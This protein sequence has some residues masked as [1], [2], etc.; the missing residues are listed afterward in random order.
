MKKFL[1]A[2]S[3]LLLCSCVHRE[4]YYVFSFDDYSITPGYDD[5]SF[6]DIAFDLDVPDSLEGNEKLKSVNMT[7]FGKYFGDVDLYNPTNKAIDIKDGKLS[8]LVLYFSQ[9]TDHT[10]KIDG[11]DL[12]KSIKKNC[13]IFNGEYIVRNGYACAIGKKVNGKDN[14]IILY[15]DIYAMDQDELNHLEIY[16]EE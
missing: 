3:L 11:V 13:E 1:L 12:E 4:D 16:A 7:F 14:V 8:R 15:G 9:L 5:V 10:F 6:L 2:L